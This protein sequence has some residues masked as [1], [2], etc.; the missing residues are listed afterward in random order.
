M[1]ETEEISLLTSVG[2]LSAKH[3]GCV[4]CKDKL[5]LIKA[6][7]PSATDGTSFN[8]SLCESAYGWENWSQT[9]P[10]NLHQQEPGTW[11]RALEKVGVCH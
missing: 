10:E 11:S 4:W 1:A 2:P 9:P 3:A 7:K 5:G 6:R 8:V